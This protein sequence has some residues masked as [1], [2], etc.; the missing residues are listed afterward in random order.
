MEVKTISERSHE[1]SNSMP[2]SRLDTP[3]QKN[4]YGSNSISTN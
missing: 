3:Q 2:S 1:D 4:H